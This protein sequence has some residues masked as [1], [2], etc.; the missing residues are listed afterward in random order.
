M[1]DTQDSNNF[2]KYQHLESLTRPEMQNILLQPE[3]VCTEKIHGTNAR[4]GLVDGV[5]RI[6]GRNQDHTNDLQGD[7]VMGFVKWVRESGLEQRLRDNFSAASQIIF[8]GEWF[9][10]SIQKGINYGKEKQF[11]VFDVKFEGRYADWDEVVWFCNQVDLSTVPLLYRGV[12]KMSEFEALLDIQSAVA[13]ELGVE[14]SNNLHEGIVIKP[15]KMAI[16]DQTGEWLIAKYKPAR[17]SERHSEKEKKDFKPVPAES[18]KFVEEFVTSTR[19]EHVLDHLRDANIPID[20]IKS[21]PHILKEMSLDIYREAAPEIEV[22]Q[23]NGIE[24][25][26]L[27]KLVAGR[28]SVLFREHLHQNLLQK[29]SDD[30]SKEKGV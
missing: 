2:T 26:T 16:N 9:G 25:K 5:L 23:K 8:F 22:L 11:R 30:T 12:P 20:D 1:T 24:W 13:K 3:V 19:L 15:T 18:Y 6:G 17:W 29:F 7:S 27:S 21:M 4:V 10:S 28:T 14:T